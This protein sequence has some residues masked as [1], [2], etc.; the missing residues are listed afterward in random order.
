MP[1][2]QTTFVN[3]LKARFPISNRT[4]PQSLASELRACQLRLSDAEGRLQQREEELQA[5]AAEVGRLARS[6]PPP[7]R[8]RS[9]G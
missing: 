3:L 6:R 4:H 7:R 9:A 2:F 8:P 5:A 1:F